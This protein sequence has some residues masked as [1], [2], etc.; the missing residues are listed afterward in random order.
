[1]GDTGT[2]SCSLVEHELELISI[3]A[4]SKATWSL[5]SALA[6]VPKPVTPPSSSPLQFLHIIELLK[7]TPREGWRRH[8]I[9][10]GE[11]IADHM[12]R[13][14]IIC[15]L[16]PPSSGLDT[17]KCVKMAIVHDMAESLVGDIT[18][19]D[20]VPKDEKHRRELE[21]MKHLTDE[22]IKPFNPSAAEELMGLWDEYEEGVSAEAMFVKDGGWS[23]RSWL[24]ETGLLMNALHS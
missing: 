24:I 14:A 9:L 2:Q 17:A 22:L 10:H 12:Y 16:A 13:M 5:K 8:N 23:F 15:M 18:P 6:S 21:T 7:K 3:P 4:N 1:M 19:V 11:S 20:N